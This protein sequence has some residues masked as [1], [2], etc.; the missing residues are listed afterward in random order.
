LLVAAVPIQTALLG[1]F[2]LL[3]AKPELSL[4]IVVAIAMIDGPV[5][6]ALAGF[7]AG[8]LLDSQTALPDGLA[9]LVLAATGACVGRFR[10]LIQRPS[11]WVPAAS[12][13]AA[14]FASLAVYAL[15]AELL[16]APTGSPVRTLARIVLAAAYGAALTPLVYPGLQKLLTDRPKGVIGSVVSR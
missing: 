5:T 15:F 6:G 7:G 10:L 16:G 13:G 4:L 8:L 2:A 11:A 3:G 9:A 14:T 1:R 12:V